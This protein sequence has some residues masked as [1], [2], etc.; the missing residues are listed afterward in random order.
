L[1][2]ESGQLRDVIGVY[3][4]AEKPLNPDII[5]ENQ[6]KSTVPDAA[7]YHDVI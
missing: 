2:V 4:Q 7:R 6:G 5:I 3:I 1:R